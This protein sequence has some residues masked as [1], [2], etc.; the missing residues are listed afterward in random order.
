MYDDAPRLAK[1]VRLAIMREHHN[2]LASVEMFC[3]G[4]AAKLKRYA[5]LLR[6]VASVKAN[7]RAEMDAIEQPCNA[8][9]HEPLPKEKP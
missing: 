4:T 6:H 2:A 1:E 5:P 8:A 7:I 9:P 3:T